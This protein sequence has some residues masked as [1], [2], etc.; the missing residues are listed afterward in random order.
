MCSAGLCLS[1][2]FPTLNALGGIFVG[3]LVYVGGMSAAQGLVS[4]GAW[5]LFI[6]SLDQFFFP[7]L[8]LTSFWAQIQG[9][10]IRCRTRLRIDR[11]RPEC[12]PKRKTG[13]AAT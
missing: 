12:D 1:L 10:L 4:I 13:C 6:M 8:N 7:V 9:G 3:V 11:C 5:Y 2:V